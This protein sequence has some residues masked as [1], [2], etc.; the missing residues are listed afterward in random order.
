MPSRKLSPEQS[1][2]NLEIEQIE[3]EVFDEEKIPEKKRSAAFQYLCLSIICD[4]SINEIDDEDIID[5]KD[6][7]GIDIVNLVTLKENTVVSIFNCKS[8][9]RSSYS[10]SDLTKLGRGLQYIFEEKQEVYT[11]LQ[12]SKLVKKISDIRD[13]KEK[14]IEVNVYYCVFNGKSQQADVERKESEIKCVFNGKSQ[15]ADV[16]R[17]ESEIKSRYTKFLKSQYPNAK[18]NLILANSN[19]LFKVKTKRDE[20]LRNVIIKIPYFDRDR[21]MRPEVQAEEIIGYLMTVKGKELARLVEE[22][23]DKLFEKNIRGWLKFKQSNRDIYESCTKNDSDIF[24][25]M[26]NGI[27]IVGDKVTV[28]DDKAQCSVKNLQI[29]NGQQTARMIYEARKD[30]K[31]KDDVKVMCRIFQGVGPDFINKVAKSTNSQLSIG[32]RD[33]MSNDPIQIAIGETF[34]KLGIFYERQRGQE[35]PRKRFKK[36]ISSKKLAQVSLAVLCKKPSLARKNIEDNF[37]NKSKNYDQ[38]F[39]RNPEEL[40][41]AYFLFEFCDQKSKEN[42]KNELKYFGTL[43]IARI[44]WQYEEN[45][46]FKNTESALRKFEGGKINLENDYKRASRFLSKILNKKKREENFVSIGHYL[47]RIEFDDILF[48]KLSK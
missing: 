9:E 41:L 28:D 46:L 1:A 17:K 32:A 25:F 22:Y 16:E 2:I 35:K 23:G 24:W 38:I 6:E 47:S 21:V 30:N 18:F 34:E 10:A 27:T 13:D 19:Y 33:L 43:H 37:F 4:L 3:K 5:G 42:K 14:V 48:S 7:E 40:L 45:S 11:K 12:N 39:N 26:N 29:V 8:S 15:Q 20:S 44:I 31:L 36:N